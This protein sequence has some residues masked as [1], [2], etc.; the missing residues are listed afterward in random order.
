MNRTQMMKKR[1][2]KMFEADAL[3]HYDNRLFFAQTLAHGQETDEIALEKVEEIH[4]DIAALAH[5]LITIKEEEATAL[6]IL[7]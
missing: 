3:I 6:P 1:N 7:A 2:G 4:Q 5:K